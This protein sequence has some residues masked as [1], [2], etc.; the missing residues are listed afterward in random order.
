[1]PGQVSQQALLEIALSLGGESDPVTLLGRTLPLLVRRTASSA[2]GV[3]ALDEEGERTVQVTP[4]V[5]EGRERWAALVTASVGSAAR[6]D[7]ASWLLPAG[8]D[9]VV[10]HVFRLPGYGLLVLARPTPLDPRFVAALEPVM[11]VLARPLVVAREQQRREAVEHDLADL[12]DRQQGLLDALPF[13]AWMADRDGR[14]LEVNLAFADWI[15]RDRSQVVGRLPTEV[16]PAPVARSCLAASAEVVAT[17]GP[18]REEHQDAPTGRTFEHDHTP[19]RDAAGE[20][21]GVVGFR[22][23]ITDRVETLRRLQEQSALQELLMDLAVGFVNT[24]VEQLDAGIDQALARIGRFAGADRAYVFSYDLAEGTTSNTHEW[25]AE[26]IEP[27][28]D[29]LQEVP[30][31]LV[32]DWV[33]TH[34]AGRTMHVDDVQALPPDSGV[35]QVLE[36]QGV[37]TLIALPIAVGDECLGFVGFDVVAVRREWTRTEHQLLRVLAELLANAEL[38]RRYERALVAAREQAEVANEAKTR[39]L[40]TISHELR[41]PMSGVLGLTELLL[42][43]DLTGHQRSYVTAARDAAEGLLL[44]VGDLLDIARI[45]QRRLELA[46]GPTDLPGLLRGVVTAARV[47]AEPRGLEVTLQLDPALPSQVHTDGARVRQIVTNLVSNAVRFTDVGRVRLSA[48]PTD[49]VGGTPT[50]AIEVCDTGVGIAADQQREVFE[51][52]IQV[53][54][55]TARR[56]GGS[57]L[58]LSIVRE[59]VGLLGGR[60]SLDSTPGVGTCVRVELPLEEAPAAEDPRVPAVTVPAGLRVLVAE[61]DPVNQKVLRGFLHSV[62]AHVEVVG[63]GQAAVEALRAGGVDVVLMD[64]SMPVL[65]GL[66]ATR[67]IRALPPPARDVPIVAVTADAAA[68]HAQACRAA[69]MDA[70]LVKP[71]DRATLVTTVAALLPE[72]TVTGSE[73]STD[74]AGEDPTGGPELSR[75]PDPAP[76][77]VLDPGPLRAMTGRTAEDG[78]LV[79]RLLELFAEHA[80]RYVRELRTSADRADAA[81]FRVAAHALRSSAA[82]LGLVRLRQ[83]CTRAE[84]YALAEATDRA[85]LAALARGVGEELD[86]AAAALAEGRESG[87]LSR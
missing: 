60:I 1:M 45:E 63:D 59:L 52:F 87:M 6:T 13:A 20:V 18:V 86:R 73:E 41:T 12:G 35:R 10:P 82:T 71:F 64:G 49:G 8:T 84:E 56:V 55:P 70:V 58:G 47:D 62:A 54:A 40:S 42:D 67:R 50:F 17:G 66:G 21:R 80:P 11:D 43:D 3:I 72:G 4:R 19:Y 29:S 68:S 57:G 14:L 32:P 9:G 27:Q 83:A 77:P 22:R 78:P 37:V 15:G 7:A 26:G 2:C 38:R 53:D 25:C 65:D 36:P 61:D 44:L 33:E 75:D 34:L 46:L 48:A 69:G 81:S 39:F 76:G 16:L 31:E 51:P 79:E 24:P 28:L 23:D 74:E 30:L 5:L 85:A